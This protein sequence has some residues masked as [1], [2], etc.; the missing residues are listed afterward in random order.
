MNKRATLNTFL[1]TS[2]YG[3]CA[4]GF[5]GMMLLDVM[6]TLTMLAIFG[7]VFLVKTIYDIEVA[8]Q[9]AEMQ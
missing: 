3:L 7:V 9:K 4:A 1:I 8:K 6:Y 5:Y 2:A